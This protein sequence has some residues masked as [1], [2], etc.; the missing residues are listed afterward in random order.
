MKHPPPTRAT[1]SAGAGDRLGLVCEDTG[2]PLPAAL[3]PYCGRPIFQGLL[4]DLTAR[5]Y[6]YF[7]TFGTQLTTPVAI[8]TSDAKGNHARVCGMLKAHSFFGRPRGSFRLFNQPLVPVLEAVTGQWVL[9]E[10]LAPSLKPGGH[11]AIW[12]LMH[13][14]GI[15]KWLDGHGVRWNR[16]LCCVPCWA[17]HAVPPRDL[18]VVCIALI[19]APL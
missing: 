13:D 3:L 9:P 12:K 17:G 14:Q 11:G 2:D 16:F 19:P 18:Q 1:R 4:R 15:F 8:M 6:L 7:R 10:A 5:E